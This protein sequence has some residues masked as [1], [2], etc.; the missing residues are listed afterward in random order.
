MSVSSSSAGG[1]GS[2]DA[3]STSG[4]TRAGADAA[5]KSPSTNLVNGTSAAGARAISTQL[6]AFYFRAPVKAFFK[7]RVDYMQVARAINPRVQANEKWSLKMTTPGLLVHAVKHHGWSFIPNQVL[8]P[9]FANA[10]V[11]AI[12]YTSYL[13]ILGHFHEPSAAGARRVYPPPPLR[14]ALAAG[15]VAGGIQSL[16]AAPL[17]ALQ[18]RF[19]VNEMIE[20]KHRNMWSYAGYKLHEIGIRGVFAGYGFSF[21]KETLGYG[22]FFASFEYVKQQMYYSFLTH[23]YGR[24]R[25]RDSLPWNGD[26]SDSTS[27][28]LPPTSSSSSSSSTIIRPH[29]AVEPAFLLLAGITASLAQ[30]AIVYPLGNMQSIHYS[31]LESLDYKTLLEQGA[32]QRSSYVGGTILPRWERLHNAY[33]HAYG[34]TFAQCGKQARLVGGWRRW[35]YRGFVWQ[36]LRQVPSTSAGLIVF[37]LVRRKFALEGQGRDVVIEYEGHTIL[38][39]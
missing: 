3:E 35:L 18:T 8:P 5:A 9:L 30:Q 19:N 26:S 27:T 21:V 24:K 15:M 25:I 39:D 36:T 37:E 4:A 16:V 33:A 6:I 14:D 1:G 22:V 29:Y 28:Y 23:Y 20:A 13:N 2:G 38:L 10:S 12:L 32:L 7:M 34:E 17:D 11:G 31:R